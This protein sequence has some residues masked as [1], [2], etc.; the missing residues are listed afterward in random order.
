MLSGATNDSIS[1]PVAGDPDTQSNTLPAM[2]VRGI[3]VPVEKKV[4][5][6]VFRTLPRMSARPFCIITV[7]AVFGRHPLDGFTPMASRC[8]DASGVPLR[9]EMRKRSAND[10]TAGGRSDTTSSN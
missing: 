1:A 8:H 10:V 4:A 3:T 2:R 7:Y 9:G 5:A 6:P